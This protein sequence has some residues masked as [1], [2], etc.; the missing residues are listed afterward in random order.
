[1]TSKIRLRL[2]RH[3]L[4]FQAIDASFNFRLALLELFKYSLGCLIMTY[5]IDHAD[6]AVGRLYCSV[7]EVR[8]LDGQLS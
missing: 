6:H 2:W 1:M 7:Y 8:R 4:C 5:D 3:K